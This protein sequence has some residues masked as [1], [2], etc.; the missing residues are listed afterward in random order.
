MTGRLMTGPRI[1]ERRIDLGLRQSELARKVGI[2]PSYLNL[3]EHNHRGIGGKLL[4]EIARELKVPVA[5]LTEG[6]EAALIAALRDAA[7]RAGEADAELTRIEEMAGRFPGWAAVIAAQHARITALEQAVDN[8]SDRLTH[9]PFLSESMHDILTTITAIRSTASIL[10]QTPDLDAEWLARFHGNIF[11]D[12]RRLSDAAEALVRYFD[13]MPREDSG[14]STAADAVAGFAEGQGYHFEALEAGAPDAVEAVLDSAPVLTAEADR[15][16]ARRY[17]ERYRADALRLPLES[18]TEAAERLGHDP[19]A[20]AAETGADLLCVFRRLASLPADAGG[21]A[22]GLVVCDG[23][24]TLTFRKPLPGFSL[25]RYGAACAFWPL[26]QALI[27]PAQPLRAV[28]EMPDETRFLAHA[29][30]LPVAG[31]GFGG[32]QVVEAAMLFQRIG[33]EA[34]APPADA[35][36][37][38]VGTS[39]RICQ[40]AGC[41][42][43]R[44]PSILHQGFDLQGDAG[45]MSHGSRRGR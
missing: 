17:L 29:V 8:L 39:C 27:R 23:S 12:S 34:G 28:M 2:S 32:P 41:A 15:A 13:Q 44:E 20:L 43:R 19:G 37:Y 21:I 40:R 22:F 18:F 9:D 42:A 10:A 30:S 5:T 25:P 1:R 11:R 16:L 3:I 35:P 4:L 36:V 7:D 24:G 26:F 6:A 45:I 33:E 31:P 14:F 38:P